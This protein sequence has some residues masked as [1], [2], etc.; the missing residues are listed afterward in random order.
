M[1][2]SSIDRELSRRRVMFVTESLRVDLTWIFE[3]R[4]CAQGCHDHEMPPALV[5]SATERIN[6][7]T[8]AA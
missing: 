8:V 7:Y 4:P 1:L 6:L 2:V 3:R 5:S